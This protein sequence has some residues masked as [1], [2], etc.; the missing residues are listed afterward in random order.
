MS[1]PADR[2]KQA[3]VNAGETVKVYAG[4]WRDV[5]N[6]KSVSSG[7]DETLLPG[8]EVELETSKVISLIDS[9]EPEPE[10]QAEDKP[11]TEPEPEATPEPETEPEDKTEPEPEPKPKAK[12]K[13]TKS[14]E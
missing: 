7:I 9:S 12:R 13:R 2:I 10:P 11:Q 4:D 8:A 5:C 1:G 6:A 14:A 3:V